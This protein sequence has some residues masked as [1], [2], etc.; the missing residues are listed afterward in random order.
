MRKMNLDVVE[1]R[2]NNAVSTAYFFFCFLWYIFM[3]LTIRV[4]PKNSEGKNDY[5]IHENLI[6][7]G[8]K[9]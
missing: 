8:L 1:D 9:G 3:W 6:L 7:I 4:V 5:R 2:N